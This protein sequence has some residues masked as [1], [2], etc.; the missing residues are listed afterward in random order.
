MCAAQ[1]HQNI[2]AHEQWHL[3]SLPQPDT[4]RWYCIP[5]QLCLKPF[6]ADCLPYRMFMNKNENECVVP[7]MTHA[8]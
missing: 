5:K 7:V 3:Y 1:S 6:I 8:L 2:C 4:L